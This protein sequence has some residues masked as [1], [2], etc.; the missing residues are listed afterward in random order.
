MLSTFL[1]I[2]RLEQKRVPNAIFIFAIQ[3]DGESRIA[4]IELVYH[5]Y[6]ETHHG[7]KDSGLL[8]IINNFLFV[9]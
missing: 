2:R 9:F 7:I 8:V 4:V 3:A 6:E 1:G 5:F